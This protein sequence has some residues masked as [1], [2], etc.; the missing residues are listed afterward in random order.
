MLMSLPDKSPPKHTPPKHTPQKHT[1]AQSILTHTRAPSRA[2]ASRTALY[3][4]SRSPRRR[5][6]LAE[7]GFAFTSIDADI[8][9]GELCPQGS[10]PECWVAALAYMKA[11]AGARTIANAGL[12]DDAPRAIVLGADTV[13]YKDGQIIGQPQNSEQAHAIITLLQDGQH[14]VLTGVAL[15]DA[16]NRFERRVIFEGATVRFG[17]LTDDQRDEYIESENWRGKAGAYNLFDRQDAGWPIEAEGDPTAIVGLPM[18]RLTE[19]LA[20]LG[21]TPNH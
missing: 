20:A 16:E 1:R 11:A 17:K 5:A 8:D 4:A 6:L 14:R 9:D 12:A 7:A 18:Q 21:V 2:N 19:E 3:L 15:L 10:L 13:C